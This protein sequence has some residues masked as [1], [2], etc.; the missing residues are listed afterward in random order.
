MSRMRNTKLKTFTISFSISGQYGQ[1]KFQLPGTNQPGQ[2]ICRTILNAQSSGRIGQ[3][4]EQRRALV[5]RLRTREQTPDV[6]ELSLGAGAF[7][8]AARP[9]ARTPM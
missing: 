4:S 6:G 3:N 9:R 2:R 7:R 5:T 1:P 8:A